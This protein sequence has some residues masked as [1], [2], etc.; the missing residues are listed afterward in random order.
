[1]ATKEK[2]RHAR[3]RYPVD[4]PVRFLVQG[5]FYNG[6]LRNIS[7]SGGFIET[8]R[9]FSARQDI[10]FYFGKQNMIGVIV[11]DELDGI[12]VKFNYPI[13]TR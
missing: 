9:T 13:Y 12:R 2:R 7:K 6:L 3:V 11:R 10:S 1:M 4:A 5:Q 8:N